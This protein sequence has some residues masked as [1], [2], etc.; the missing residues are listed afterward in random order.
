MYYKIQTTAK[1]HHVIE[2][3]DGSYRQKRIPGLLFPLTVEGKKQAE[4]VAIALTTAFR[5]GEVYRQDI[6]N[7]AYYL[8]IDKIGKRTEDQN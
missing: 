1:G 5:K 2:P 8:F 3:E 4:L 7:Q 6:I